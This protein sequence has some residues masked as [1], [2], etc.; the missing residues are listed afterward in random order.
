MVGKWQDKSL[1]EK[2]VTHVKLKSLFYGTGAARFLR[3][4]PGEFEL[5]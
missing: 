3:G 2:L 5:I 1:G 4:A